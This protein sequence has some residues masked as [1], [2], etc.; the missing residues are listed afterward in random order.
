VEFLGE[1]Y[2][3]GRV[4][5]NFVVWRN[6]RQVQRYKTHFL[7]RCFIILE[8]DVNFKEKFIQRLGE[9]NGIKKD[10]VYSACII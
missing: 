3:E 8:I 2:I 6:W 7:G 5:D 1:K 9:I 4:S 10:K